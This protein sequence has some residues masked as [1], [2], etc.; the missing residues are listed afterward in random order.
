MT[1][2]IAL[3]GKNPVSYSENLSDYFYPD[4]NYVWDYSMV[5]PWRFN[6]R[7]GTIV[8]GIMALDAEKENEKYSS[9]KLKDRGG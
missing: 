3:D 7:A 4:M 9:G 1:S 2:N 8:G 5:T 6:V